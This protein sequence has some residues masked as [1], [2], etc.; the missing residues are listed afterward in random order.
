MKTIAFP[1][2][3]TRFRENKSETNNKSYT[4]PTRD[5]TKEKQYIHIACFYSYGR[6]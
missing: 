3:M 1:R 5:Y 2:K 6:H 4:L